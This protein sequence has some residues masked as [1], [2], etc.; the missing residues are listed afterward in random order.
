MGEQ[1]RYW[2]LPIQNSI[3][4]GLAFPVSQDVRGILRG[5]RGNDIGMGI[6]E[7]AVAE[8]EDERVWRRDGRGGWMVHD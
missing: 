4:N 5:M 2:F 3:G 7:S 6:E 1:R 8:E